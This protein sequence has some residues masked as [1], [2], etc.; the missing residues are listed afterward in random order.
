VG[1]LELARRDPLSPAVPADRVSAPASAA[2]PAELETRLGHHFADRTLLR[3]ALTH[4]SSVGRGQRA[5]SSNERLE[6]L[7]DRVLGLAIADLL[8]ASFPQESE[9]AL[10]KR[11]AG[12]VCRETLAEVALE[13]DLGGAL[14]LGRSEEEAAGRANPA[15]LADALEAL[16]G[17][18]YRDAGL[19]PAQ[20]FIRRHWRAR[21]EEMRSPPRDPKTSLQEWAQGRGLALPDYQVVEVGGAA[22]A[23]RFEVSVRVAELPPA[24]AVAGSKRAAERAA[25]EQLLAVLEAIDD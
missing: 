17:A 10:T 7:G 14:V 8:M 2:P 22:H 6:F 1:D 16:I 5:R 25:A 20:A 15:I 11:Q 9:G 3:E 12:L 24:R 4:S 13:L 19:G 23:P 21:L 18:I